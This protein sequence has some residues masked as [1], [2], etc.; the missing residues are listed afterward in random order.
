MG[1]H[2]RIF[3]NDGRKNDVVF[4]TYVENSVKASTGIIQSIRIRSRVQMNR[5]FKGTGKYS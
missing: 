2:I 4:D 1:L 5:M 3:W